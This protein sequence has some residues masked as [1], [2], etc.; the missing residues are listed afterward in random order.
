MVLAKGISISRALELFSE[1]T[2]E[3]KE[4]AK[5]ITLAKMP[6][7]EKLIDQMKRLERENHA[8]KKHSSKL[9]RALN[10]SK[11]KH[12]KAV[13]KTAMPEPK[14]AL[15]ARKIES[16]WSHIRE[17]EKLIVEGAER[18]RAANM[19]LSNIKG[20]I[21]AKKLDNLSW[22]E[23]LKKKRLLNIREGDILLVNSLDDF[24]Q[25]CVDEIKDKNLVL[26]KRASPRPRVRIGIAII[27]V[28]RID[29]ME[30]RNFASMDKARLEEEKAKTDVLRNVIDSYRKERMK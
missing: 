17:K 9:I 3:P 2:P 7:A 16:L 21:I 24:S 14:D 5:Q 1:K 4:A 13:L 12:R 20:K 28:S 25:R 22:D 27:D 23:Y 11:T 8:L 10:K 26:S 19:M 6:Q 15:A 30:T 18:E 29:M